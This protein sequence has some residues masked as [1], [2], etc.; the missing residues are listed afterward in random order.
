MG[1]KLS[2]RGR[3]GRSAAM[4]SVAVLAAGGMV[5]TAGPVNAAV[6]QGGGVNA[7]GVPSFYRDAEGLALQLCVDANEVNCEPPVDDHIGVYFAADATAGPL[8]ALYAVEAVQDPELGAIVTNG[9]RFRI[10][11]ARANT[12]Y[13]IR[14]PWGSNT[15]RTN[16]TGAADCRLES[17]G[18]AGTVAAGHVKTFL[19][20]LPRPASAFIGNTDLTSSVAGSPT[21]FNR[22]TMTGGGQR[23]STDQFTLMGQ[24]RADTAM[25]SISTRSL[26]L[27]R[28]QRSEPVVRNIRYA[29]FGTSNA[30]PTIRLGGARP[31]AFSVRNTCGTMAPGSACSIEV[32]F[33]P[34]QHQNRIRTAVLTIDDNSLAAPRQV[35]LRGVGFRTN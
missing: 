32:T 12:R 15:C 3:R 2:V 1:M 10:Q 6:T 27:G 28:P 7:Q 11:G 35:R 13:T 26:T 17:G 29:S 30:R 18:E 16:A 4:L 31:R 20:A 34:R 25:S 8:T 9:T 33:R 24:K 5:A 19:R 23:F 14:D 21:G 22:V